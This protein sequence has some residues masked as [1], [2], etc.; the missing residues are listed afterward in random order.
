MEQRK[1]QWDQAGV[2]RPLHQLEVADETDEG[3]FR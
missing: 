3:L 2:L 1:C